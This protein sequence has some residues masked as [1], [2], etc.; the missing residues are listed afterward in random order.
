MY[1]IYMYIY[2]DVY[3]CKICKKSVCSYYSGAFYPTG[4]WPVSRGWRKADR[5]RSTWIISR[6]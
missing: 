2:V 4:V 5:S 3:I 1:I 6:Y